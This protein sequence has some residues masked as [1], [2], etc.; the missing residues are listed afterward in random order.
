MPIHIFSETQE[1]DPFKC[2]I[3]EIE[4]KLRSRD[5]LFPS[6]EKWENDDFETIAQIIDDYISGKF[7]PTKTAKI[8]N[9]NNKI[10]VIMVEG[11]LGRI[12]ISKEGKT[13]GFK[14]KGEI[15]WKEIYWIS[16]LT[17]KRM[18]GRTKHKGDHGIQNK[19]IMAAFAGY[20]NWNDF[21][22]QFQGGLTNRKKI[23]PNLTDDLR[24]RAMFLFGHLRAPKYAPYFYRKDELTKLD[25]AYGE[26]KEKPI[27]KNRDKYIE[28]III[29]LRV[30][31]YWSDIFKFEDELPDVFVRVEKKDMIERYNTSAIIREFL[32]KYNEMYKVELLNHLNIEPNEDATILFKIS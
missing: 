4:W 28:L 22:R 17:L 15:P 27:P 8:S 26:Y 2:L 29:S 12:T 10:E 16:V 30:V 11:K 23:N 9:P 6:S 24:I 32:R 19:N 18:W 21:K 13:K 20:K 7:I 5:Y 31:D 14:T 1:D 25:I 3:Q